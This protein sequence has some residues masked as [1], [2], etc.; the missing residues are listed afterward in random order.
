M[1][2]EHFLF[3]HTLERKS[4]LL[5]YWKQNPIIICIKNQQGESWPCLWNAE[6]NESDYR[7]DFR[8]DWIQQSTVLLYT[9]QEDCRKNTW[10]IQENMIVS[11]HLTSQ[12]ERWSVIC[13]RLTVSTYAQNIK[14]KVSTLPQKATIRSQPTPKKQ[15]WSLNLPL[16]TA[17]LRSRHS[18]Q[19]PVW[20]QDC[21]KIKAFY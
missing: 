14:L 8:K 3:H 12:R 4:L 13:I 2:N 5:K 20:I 15:P 16:K 1:T 7:R 17:R 18:H 6:D 9:F 10:W 11:F 19:M 21:S